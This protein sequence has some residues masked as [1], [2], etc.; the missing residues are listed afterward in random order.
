MLEIQTKHLVEMKIPA[1][2]QIKLT[3]R[4]ELLR[5]NTPS[6]K[7]K[8]PVQKTA[9]VISSA[10]E[11]KAD[12]DNTFI[13]KKSDYVQLEEPTKET[14]VG[15]DKNGGELLQGA[16]NE[17]ES[18]QSFLEAL[19]EW[20]STKPIEEEKPK[21]RPKDSR[22]KKVRFAEP[23]KD[24][25]ETK[26]KPLNKKEDNKPF[27]FAGGETFIPSDKHTSKDTGTDTDPK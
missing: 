10:V 2:H 19:N 23:E 18:H 6:N 7:P 9:S 25:E 13:T 27:I 5:Q 8:A 14:A 12:S 15:D 1:G 11:R 24:N 26:K 17:A 3:K 20:R 21:S 22:S 16:F 4:L